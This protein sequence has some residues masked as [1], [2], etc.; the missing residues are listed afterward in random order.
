[1]LFK[2]KLL[3]YYIFWYFNNF[4]HYLL[5]GSLTVFGQKVTT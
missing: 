5:Q 4:N 2:L 3:L 1:M